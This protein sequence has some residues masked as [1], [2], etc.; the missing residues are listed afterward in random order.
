VAAHY[1]LTED[2]DRA[3]RRRHE[4]EHGTHQR[5]FARAVRPEHADEFALI[6]LQTGV[7]QDGTA[8]QFQ[9]HVLEFENGR[10]IGRCAASQSHYVVPLVTAL[11]GCR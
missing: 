7:A 11:F 3:A 4:A 8:A 1:R 6:H 10:G 2:A 9:R 5:G